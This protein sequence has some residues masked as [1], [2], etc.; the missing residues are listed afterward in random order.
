MRIKKLRVGWSL[1]Y[2]KSK[3]C[4]MVIFLLLMT[5]LKERIRA[6]KSL[7]TFLIRFRI[8]QRFTKTR[9]TSTNAIYFFICRRHYWR[10][11]LC[12]A[13]FYVRLCVFI[14]L[15]H[16]N[17]S[18]DLEVQFSKVGSDKLFSIILNLRCRPHISS[19]ATT[20]TI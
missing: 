5:S 2:F 10:W 20:C 15:Y 19:P 18:F 17:P 8:L 13:V 3:F 6:W 11:V 7:L 9:D 1:K 14:D 12:K 4:V 16:N